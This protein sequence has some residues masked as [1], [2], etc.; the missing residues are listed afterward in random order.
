MFYNMHMSGMSTTD[1]SR[2][3][4][5]RTFS[6]ICF[7]NIFEVNFVQALQS[8]CCCIKTQ[9]VKKCA[10][11]EWLFAVSY[12]HTNDALPW[13]QLSSLNVE[14]EPGIKIIICC[15]QCVLH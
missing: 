10:A 7:E 6:S 14:D 8:I 13:Q 1:I 11:A 2:P 4:Q 3:T 5:F 9:I 15:N 12:R